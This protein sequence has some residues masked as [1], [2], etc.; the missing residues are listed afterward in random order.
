MSIQHEQ[1]VGLHIRNKIGELSAVTKTLDRLAADWRLPSSAMIQLQ[2]ALDEVLSN[3]IKYAWS[4]NESHELSVRFELKESS[5]QVVIEDDGHP[6]DPRAH[7][8]RASPESGSRREPGGVGIQMVKQLV[9]ELSYA[10]SDG[11]NQIT[12]TKTFLRS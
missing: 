9:D 8:P 5:V 11:R 3:I 1:T 10:R 12:L 2:V 6:F 4:Q 7:T